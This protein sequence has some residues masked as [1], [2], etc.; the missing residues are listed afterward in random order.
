MTMLQR[1]PVQYDGL[2]HKLYY[3]G[4]MGACEFVYPE[5]VAYSDGN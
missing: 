4:R 5:T 1:T 2:F 3:W